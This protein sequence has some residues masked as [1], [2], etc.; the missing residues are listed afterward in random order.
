M[1]KRYLLRTLLASCCSLVVTAHADTPAPAAAYN[2]ADCDAHFTNEGSFLAGHKFS[3]WV[4]MPTVA[5]NDAFSR[6][7]IALSKD[8]YTIVSSDRDGGIISASQSVS[9]GKGSTA[10]LMVIVEPL[11]TNGSKL[12]ATFRI[13]GGQTVKAEIVRAKLCEYL[14]AA[15]G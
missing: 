4:E 8:G 3:T 7:S 12:M 9:F 15:N 10:P 11:N 13:G 2:P 5:K 1:I 14:G 6:T